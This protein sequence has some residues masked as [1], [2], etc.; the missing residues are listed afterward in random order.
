MS[1]FTDGISAVPSVLVTIAERAALIAAGVWLV[2]EREHV[3]RNALGGAIAI[4]LF[5]LAWTFNK[6]RANQ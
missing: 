1:L 6:A 5:V 2:G 4:E 3:V